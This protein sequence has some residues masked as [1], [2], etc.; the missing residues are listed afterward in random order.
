MKVQHHCQSEGTGWELRRPTGASSGWQALSGATGELCNLGEGA[1]LP[2][3]MTHPNLCKD[4]SQ[5]IQAA[6]ASGS[7][8]Q[9][10][11]AALP[12]GGP[13]AATEGHLVTLLS[14]PSCC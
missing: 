3:S 14:E 4:Q 1:L 6:E 5:R 11:S 8:W 12:G 9:Q 13:V 7:Q 10:H 2:E